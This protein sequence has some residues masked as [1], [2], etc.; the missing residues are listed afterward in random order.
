MVEADQT[1]EK[2]TLLITGC[3][4]GIGRC[5]AEGMRERG[6]RVFATARKSADVAA[7]HQAGFESCRIDLADSASI[8]EGLHWVLEQTGGG[9]DALFNNGAYGQPGALED[10]TREAL[11]EQFET[12]LFGTHELTRLVLPVMRQQGAGRIVQ[13]SSILGFVGL[14]FRGAYVASKFALAGLTE[15]MRL[16]MRGSGID[17]ILIEPG[18]I[19]SDFRKN[20]RQAFLKHINAQ[21]SIYQQ[22]YQ[23]WSKQVEEG[24][25][26]RFTLPPQAVLDKVILA[27]E[28][29]RPKL[30]YG[31]TTPTHVF[32]VLRCLLPRRWV[33]FLL[34]RAG[35]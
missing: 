35:R 3:S 16:E 32:W 20:A 34:S 6:W 29:R 8:Q 28:S 12:N 19:E 22:K 26:E 24:V 15:S 21:K 4:T 30:R 23:G 9:L 2:R 18:P 14:P 10:L 11:R 27:L 17:F 25:S 33:D 13:N 7:L 31:V 1:P 5:V